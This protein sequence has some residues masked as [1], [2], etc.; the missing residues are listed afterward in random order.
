MGRESGKTGEPPDRS[1]GLTMGTGG[2][3]G[4]MQVKEGLA[5]PK[6]VVRAHS[7][8]SGTSLPH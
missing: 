8:S 5:R 1:A 4:T 6:P 2:R 7:S 3:E